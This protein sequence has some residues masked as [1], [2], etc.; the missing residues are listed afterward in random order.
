MR[1][2][3]SL[4]SRAARSF[5][6]RPAGGFLLFRFSQVSLSAFCRPT[7]PR[8][9]AW[10]QSPG[11]RRPRA[12]VPAPPRG[13][14]PFRLVVKLGTK[15]QTLCLHPVTALPYGSREGKRGEG[16]DGTAQ[17]ST[18]NAAPGQPPAPRCLH[19]PTEPRSRSWG[20]CCLTTGTQEQSRGL[21]QVLAH[22]RRSWERSKLYFYHR[23]DPSCLEACCCWTA[24]VSNKKSQT[25]FNASGTSI[26]L[27]HRGVTKDVVKPRQ[28]SGQ[29]LD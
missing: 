4:F 8:P 1:T 10:E 11:S 16:G 26:P 5:Q 29:K 7:N 14:L 24:L 23:G 2:H 21:Q 6:P 28:S 19:R 27:L 12:G 9:R 17:S 20:C 25:S 13:L 3:L 18:Q 15:I 22:V